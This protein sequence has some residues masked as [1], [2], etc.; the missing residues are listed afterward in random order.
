[1][2]PLLEL[3]ACTMKFGG[4]TA[5]SALDVK[6]GPNDLIGMIGPNGAGKTTA[7]NMITGVYCPTSG[8]VLFDGRDL[9][10][11]KPYDIVAA[12]IARTF[13]NIRLFPNLTVYENVQVSLNKSL[14][15]GF[16][17]SVLQLKN[18]CD[19]EKA[20]SQVTVEIL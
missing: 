14:K 15:H 5:V 9:T 16:S 20:I 19:E 17:H 4:L 3:Q 2:K 7:F 6:I 13:Q 1:M 11:K 12:G 18:F 10:R 8:S